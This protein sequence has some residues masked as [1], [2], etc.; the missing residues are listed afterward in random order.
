MDALLRSNADVEVHF[1]SFPSLEAETRAISDKAVSTNTGISPIVFHALDGPTHAEA[2]LKGFRQVYGENYDISTSVFARPLSFS[3]AMEAIADLPRIVLPW[4]GPQ[5]M[6]VY[7]SFSD[8]IKTVAP[9]LV[10]LDALLSPAVTSAWNSGTR[11]SYLC[12]NALKDLVIGYQKLD[13]LWN[14]PAL[15]SGYDYPLRWFQ[16]PTNIFYHLAMLYRVASNS[17][18]A[19]KKKYVEDQTGQPLRVLVGKSTERPEFVKIFV[20]SLLE[21]EFPLRSHKSVVACGPIIQDAPKVDESDPQLSAWLARGRTIYVNMGS[22][23]RFTEDSA[24]ELSKG[25][26]LVLDQLDLKEPSLPRT[27]VLW[28]LASKSGN[29]PVTASNAK[30]RAAFCGKIE[31]DR[32]RILTWLETPPLAVLRSGGIACS[33]HHGGASSYHEAILAGVPH[34]VLPFWTDCYDFANRVEYL[35]IGRKGSRKQQPVFEA[36]EF[37]DAVLEVIMGDDSEQMKRKAREL[38]GVSEKESTT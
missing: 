31:D 9:D 15:M 1:A 20:G 18:F 21:L 6:K 29:A 37:S 33:V 4:D 10:I 26:N 7:H 38:A 30:I 28:K 3:T 35:G 5:F 24:A 13:I 23:F 36:A 8:I 22:L 2:A 27:Q 14:Y 12:P 11:F 16:R 25:L 32:V 19:A 34:V 17:E